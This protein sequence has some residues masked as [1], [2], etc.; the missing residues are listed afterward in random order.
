MEHVYSPGQHTIT[1]ITP[2][3]EELM[4]EYAAYKRGGI[5]DLVEYPSGM[6]EDGR[7]EH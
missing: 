1:A 4:K 2:G 6:E 7:K 5:E 3:M